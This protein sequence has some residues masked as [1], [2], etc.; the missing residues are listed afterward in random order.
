MYTIYIDLKASAKV[1]SMKIQKE[2][3]MDV[4]RTS[5]KE[6]QLLLFRVAAENY[7]YDL[8]TRVEHNIN[9]ASVPGA[10]HTFGDGRYSRSCSTKTPA[11]VLPANS[12]QMSLN[13][14][15]SCFRDQYCSLDVNYSCYSATY[16]DSINMQEGGRLWSLKPNGIRVSPRG[17]K[18]SV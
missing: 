1:K 12:L 4:T 15:S 5:V 10:V 2:M 7:E 6:W 3:S 14:F 18:A 16:A 17:A 8:M 11:H 13:H 9:L